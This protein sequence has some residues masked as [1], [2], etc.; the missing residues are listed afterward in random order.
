VTA[1]H[2][3]TATQA[4]AA[5][6]CGQFCAVDYATALLER[7]ETCAHLN[8]FS[9]LD[10]G[11]ILR[12]ARAS[13]DLRKSSGETGPLH[14]LP[15]AIKDNINVAGQPTTAGTPALRDHRPANDAPVVA[16]LRR[17]GAILFGRTNMHELAYGLTGNNAAFGAVRNPHDP[18]RIAGGSSGGSAAAVA[19]RI[20]PVALGTDTGGSVRVPAALCGIVGFR[21]THGRYSGEG[22]V[23]IAQ[24]RDT[25]GILAR[26]VAD[27]VLL[28]QVLS[29]ETADTLPVE[30]TDLRIGIPRA[31]FHDRLDPDIARLVDAALKALSDE[32]A[33]LVEANIEGMENCNPDIGRPIVSGEVLHDLP[34][35]LNRYT[36]GITMDDILAQVASPDVR[37][38][39]QSQFDPANR[40]GI[41]AGYQRAKTVS[42]PHLFERFRGFFETHE[43]DVVAF[44]TTRVSATP[45][46]DNEFT[47]PSGA[48]V[49]LGPE[50]V[51][52]TGP[53]SIIGLPGLTFPV[54][55]TPAGLPVGLELEADARQDVR[56]LSVAMGCE[57]V[58]QPDCC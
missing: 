24:S 35:Y 26:N 54:G 3:L 49:A 13:D 52:N 37:E 47:D 45:I 39:I 6:R 5:M 22:I 21:P 34:R 12:D 4:L 9:H 8:A 20:V 38:I 30:M 51:H 28:D 17:A 14:G 32:G 48:R 10:A 33:K 44:P 11:L 56:L 25:V 27:T 19:A 31:Y 43:L 23:P 16:A 58:L 29:G 46:G 41:L 50:L 55:L 42:H 53:S 7:A 1:L 15:V 36:D 40:A 2:D 18:Q 57:R